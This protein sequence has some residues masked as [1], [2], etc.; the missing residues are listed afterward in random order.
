VADERTATASSAP[1]NSA[2]RSAYP[3][4]IAAE[5]ASGTA[6]VWKLPLGGGGPLKEAGS[7][8]C[9]LAVPPR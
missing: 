5:L 2:P 1:V 3:T 8:G 9:L 4:W 6:L 7:S